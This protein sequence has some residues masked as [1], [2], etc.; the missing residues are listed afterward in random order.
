MPAEFESTP[1][2]R[3]FFPAWP[4]C[5]GS[6]VNTA[7][8]T[9]TTAT[10]M[11]SSAPLKPATESSSPPAKKPAP[12]NAF[13][14]PVN[15]AT[16]LNNPESSPFGTSTLTALFALIFVRSF[17]IPESAWHPITQATDAPVPH[18]GSSNA[19]SPSAPACSAS[20]PTSVVRTPVRDATHPPTRF[21]TMPKNSYRRNRK[22]S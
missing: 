10:A 14:E 21:V 8:R 16:H 13:F 22:A 17:A 11:M 7:P 4:M 6:V 15:T 19:S 3:V 1:A 20:P 2:N 9:A 12:F 5:A 18:A